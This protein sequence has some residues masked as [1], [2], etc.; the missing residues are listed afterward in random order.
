MSSQRPM[1]LDL[2]APSPSARCRPPT[3]R[4]RACRLDRSMCG[5]SE[6]AEGVPSRHLGPASLHSTR[7]A[8][9]APRRHAHPQTPSAAAPPAPS[10][11]PALFHAPRTRLPRRTS[12]HLPLLHMNLPADVTPGHE[13]P[14]SSLPELTRFTTAPEHASLPKNKST[15]NLLSQRSPANL[16][17]S[18]KRMSI[19]AGQL[20]RMARYVSGR[21][22]WRCPPVC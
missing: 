17:V 8:C 5:R 7:H 6:C 1:P 3:A 2:Q 15:S 10:L 19:D 9:G 22:S 18:T 20:D 13:E 21:E 16:S 14:L 4:G 12:T 11:S